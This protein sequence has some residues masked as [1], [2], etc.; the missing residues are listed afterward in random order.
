[1]Y[2]SRIE[3]VFSCTDLKGHQMSYTGAGRYIDKLETVVQKWVKCFNEMKTVYDLP[4]R[5]SK[6]LITEIHEKSS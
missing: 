2:T 4:E 1:M 3:A 6:H 5:D